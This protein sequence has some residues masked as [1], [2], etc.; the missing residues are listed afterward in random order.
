MGKKDVLVLDCTIRD[1]GLVNKWDFSEDF[2]RRVY[3]SLSEAGV[4]YMEVGYKNSPKI[5]DPSGLGPWQFSPDELIRRAIPVKTATKLSAVVDYGRVDEADI[6]PSHE[7]PLDLIRVACYN[8]DIREALQLVEHIHGKGYETSIN[9]MAVST[10][11]LQDIA[12]SLREIGHS[13][14][15]MAYIVDSYGSLMPADIEEW[16]QLFQL[17]LP[18]KRIGVHTHNNLQL[19]FANTVQAAEMGVQM[20]DASLYGMGRAAGN[21]PTELVLNYVAKKSVQAHKYQ[22]RPVLDV[23]KRLFIPL[24]EKEEW[25]YII[26][27]TLTGMLN[28]HPRAAMKLR[29]SVSKDDYAEFYDSVSMQGKQH[30]GNDVVQKV[31]V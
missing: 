31:K 14:V 4:D 12:E 29:D 10:N 22:L 18:H 23:I 5:I 8:D 28:E 20:L 17:H 13:C 7:S 3:E 6:L 25:G 30:A 24:R 11:D 21:C 15:D 19:A 16:V 27:Y 9:I 2:V 1:G 26:P